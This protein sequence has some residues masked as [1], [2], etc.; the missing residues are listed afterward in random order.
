MAVTAPVTWLEELTVAATAPVTWL[1][2]L[3]VAASALVTLVP[4]PTD[5]WFVQ[6]SDRYCVV[7]TSVD[8]WESI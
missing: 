6:V 7:Q 4:R 5:W 1:E 2:E 8:I 3:A